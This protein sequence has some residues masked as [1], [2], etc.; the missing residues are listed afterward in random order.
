[1]SRP[2][3]L[4]LA[5]V[6]GLAGAMGGYFYGHAQGATAEAARRDGQALQQLTGLIGSHQ[7]LIE[8]AAATSDALR[9]AQVARAAQDA[10]FSR[11]FR[12]ALKTSAAARAGCRF[13]D[14]SVRQLGAARDRAAAATSG[15]PAGGSA[16]TV[17]GPAAGAGPGGR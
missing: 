16:A 3:L 14:D 1:M 17:P 13:D 10:R 9:Q 6:A 11:E 7:A 8:Q 15:L 2:A 5:L 12:D 4:L